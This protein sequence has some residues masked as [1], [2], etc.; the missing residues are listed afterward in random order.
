M[1]DTDGVSAELVAMRALSRREHSAG[2]LR[3]KLLDK[4]FEESVVSAVLSDLRRA[5]YQDDRRFAEGMVR[6]RMARGTGPL[7]LRH[8]LRQKGVD[9]TLID[10]LVPS[11]SDAVWLSILQDVRR[12][13]YG[14]V[15][16]ADPVERA[17][18][19]RFL[20]QRGFSGQQIRMAENDNVSR[21]VVFED[22]L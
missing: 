22:R 21:E 5:G 13:R 7:K 11:E 1:T 18:Q 2:E 3:R 14:S 9:E 8:E 19:W 10:E 15:E 17:R 12:K 20:T 16:A 4:G 6:Y